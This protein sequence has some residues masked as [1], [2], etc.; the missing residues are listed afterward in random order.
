MSLDASAVVVQHV[1]FYTRSFSAEPQ[2]TASP[3]IQRV[4]PQILVYWLR[5][6]KISRPPTNYCWQLPRDFLASLLGFQSPS[7]PRTFRQKLSADLI[8]TSARMSM[9]AEKQEAATTAALNWPVGINNTNRRRLAAMAA[10]IMELQEVDDHQPMRD[11]LRARIGPLGIAG[12]Y[13]AGGNPTAIAFQSAI[14]EAIEDHA[15]WRLHDEEHRLTPDEKLDLELLVDDIRSQEDEELEDAVLEELEDRLGIHATEALRDA[16]LDPSTWAYEQWALIGLRTT[17]QIAVSEDKKET[18]RFLVDCLVSE[19]DSATRAQSHDDMRDWIGPD[20]MRTLE[21]AGKDMVYCACE[22]VLI[23]GDENRYDFSY[24][25]L[26]TLVLLP[27]INSGAVLPVVEPWGGTNGEAQPQVCVPLSVKRRRARETL[28]TRTKSTTAASGSAAT[29]PSATAIAAIAIAATA[30]AATA[31]AATATAGTAPA[32]TAP[33]AAAPLPLNI[34]VSSGYTRHPITYQLV[35]SERV[36]V[37]PVR[38]FPVWDN[39][40]LPVARPGPVR[41]C[42]CHHRGGGAAMPNDTTGDASSDAS[43][44]TSSDAAS[45]MVQIT[46]VEQGAASAPSDNAAADTLQTTRL[47]H[48]ATPGSNQHEITPASVGNAA[49]YKLQT[50]GVKQGA[51]SP[52]ADNMATGNVAT[53]TMQTTEVP[54]T[55]APAAVDNAAADTLQMTNVQHHVAPASVHDKANDTLP[56]TKVQQRVSSPTLVHH[57]VTSASVKHNL[58]PASVGNAANYT[59]PTTEA[60]HEVAPASVD[61]AANYALLTTEVQQGAVRHPRDDASNAAGSNARTTELRTTGVTQGIALLRVPRDDM[62]N[63]V[64]DYASTSQLPATEVQHGAGAAPQDDESDYAS[65]DAIEHVSGDAS[66]S[67][68]PAAEVQHGA[69]AAPH[70][71]ASDYASDDANK[72]ASHE[73]NESV[74]DDA[75]TNTPHTTKVKPGDAP[76]SGD[77]G[78]TDAGVATP[79][80]EDAGNDVNENAGND[81]INNATENAIDNVSTH[82]PHTIKAKPHNTTASDDD[83]ATDTGAAP[84]LRDDAG[85]APTH[86]DHPVSDADTEPETLQTIVAETMQELEALQATVAA[87]VED[88]TAMQTVVAAEATQDMEGLQQSIASTLQSMQM[89]LTSV[90]TATE[91]VGAVQEALALATEEGQED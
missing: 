2:S 51:V 60:Q 86:E 39:T 12:I 26:E 28:L 6:P 4:S 25:D 38:G 75:S 89:L 16:G 76:A 23:Y 56:T 72:S 73:A 67:Q 83:A 47:Q 78:A 65:G 59:M 22:H 82:T 71:N 52:L 5:R 53:D 63:C 46:G 29:A 88:I 1:L 80:R 42:V 45:D 66:T 87:A 64:G 68:L 36:A 30:A 50:T 19:Q 48:K 34:R 24:T 90:M 11:E 44:D 9:E 27:G 43:R 8:T 62:G 13:R 79:Q 74:S 21:R 14:M 70:N 69:G 18:H 61:N 41:R 7:I 84:P 40:L 77:D 3:R 57:K 58:T 37:L 10:A 85:S 31:P 49:N 55:V 17:P 32:A 91:G 35:G 81:A 20:A 33:P 15:A 54:R